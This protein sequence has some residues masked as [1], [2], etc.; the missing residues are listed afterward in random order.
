MFM[1]VEMK[2]LNTQTMGYYL[3]VKR[4]FFTYAI[5][6]ITLKNTVFSNISQT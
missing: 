5:P 3:V 2:T 4:Q 6:W 1:N